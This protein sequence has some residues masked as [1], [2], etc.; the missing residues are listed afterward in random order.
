MIQSPE[1]ISGILF[2]GVDQAGDI[3]E[4]RTYITEGV[5]DLSTDSAGIPGIILGAELA[6][7]LRASVG[8]VLTSYTIE[9]FP[10]RLIS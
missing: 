7:N 2:K 5:Y 4:M 6:R 3:S 1:E 9:G 10:R 8:S